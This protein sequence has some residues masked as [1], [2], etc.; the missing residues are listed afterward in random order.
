M[1]P[2]PIGTLRARVDARLVLAH[3]LM[4]HN[5]IGLM[6]I[7]I[8]AYVLLFR[9]HLIEENDFHGALFSEILAF[10]INEERQT[11]IASSAFYLSPTILLSYTAN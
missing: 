6:L 3:T 10:D 4:L 9:S 7:A 11:F 2:W 5:P 8:L 1:L